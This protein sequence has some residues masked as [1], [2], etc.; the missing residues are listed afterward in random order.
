MYAGTRLEPL[1]H[2]ASCRRAWCYCQ[3]PPQPR[4]PPG[5][6]AGFRRCPVS[7]SWTTA[8]GHR[9]YTGKTPYITILKISSSIC[10][11]PCRANTKRDIHTHTHTRLRAHRTGTTR[12]TDSHNKDG[13]P[14]NVTAIT[15]RAAA[16]QT[17]SDLDYREANG[18]RSPKMIQSVIDPQG[19]GSLNVACLK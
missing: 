7:C 11:Y 2:H 5:W 18:I 13:S 19:G 16:G 17:G 3:C 15:D 1:T 8:T 9:S 4:A 14:A 6:P 12:F 10:L